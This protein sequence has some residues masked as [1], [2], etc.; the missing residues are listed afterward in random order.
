MKF[1]EN[2]T[3]YGYEDVIF[4]LQL[5]EQNINISHIENPVISG[6]LEDNDRFI[7]KSGEAAVNLALFIKNKDHL[8]QEIKLVRAFKI[9]MKFKLIFI[10]HSFLSLDK[11]LE[12]VQNRPNLRNLD[13]FKLA[14]LWSIMKVQK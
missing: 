5:K 2:I 1:D 3:G 8:V 6:P 4:G 12:R 10:L 9:V 11:A 14:V 7:Q 13:L